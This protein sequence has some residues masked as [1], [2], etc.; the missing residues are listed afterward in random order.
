MSDEDFASCT[1]EQQSYILKNKAELAK[2]AVV[3]NDLQGLQITSL[4]E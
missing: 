2:H 3:D 1:P 4:K